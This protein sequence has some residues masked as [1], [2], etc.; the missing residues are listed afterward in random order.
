MKMGL[1][2]R[3]KGRLMGAVGR[4]HIELHIETHY[5]INSNAFS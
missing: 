3:T 2:I 1:E 5:S 4:Q